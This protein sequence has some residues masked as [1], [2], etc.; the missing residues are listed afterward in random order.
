MSIMMTKVGVLAKVDASLADQ[1]AVAF[2]LALFL[3]NNHHC[4]SNN[5]YTKHDLKI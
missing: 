1:A 3:G 5:H 2:L 4:M